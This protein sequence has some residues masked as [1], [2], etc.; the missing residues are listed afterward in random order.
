VN[1]GSPCVSNLD[2]PAGSCD[3]TTV[4][5]NLVSA[6]HSVNQHVCQESPFPECQGDCPGGEVCVESADGCDCVPITC[7]QSPFPE[8]NGECPPG[9]TCRPN[10][11]TGECECVPDPVPCEQ[12]DPATCDGFCLDPNDQCT[13]DPA[14]GPCFCEPPLVPCDQ[15]D[16]ATCDGPCPDPNDV[17]TIDSLGGPCFCEPPV[18]GG[19]CTQCGPGAHFIDAC[20]PFPPVGTD[21]VSNNGAVVGIDLDLDCVKDINV[22][23]HPC[24]APDNLLQVDKTLRSTTRRTSREP[25]R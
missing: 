6:N 13:P 9:T 22:V 15:S 23:M 12:S 24:A 8:C 14:G 21:L 2:C 10:D 18:Q 11:V 16:P 25:A 5:A 3:G 4:L 20:G 17:C 1:G 7:E 19:P